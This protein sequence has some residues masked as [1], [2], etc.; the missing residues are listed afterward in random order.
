MNPTLLIA[1]AIAVIIDSTIKIDVVYPRIAKQDSIARINHVP[2]NFVFGSVSPA[3]AK[4]KINRIAVPLEESGAF[5]AYLP[6]DWETQNYIFEARVDS[7]HFANHILPFVDRADIHTASTNEVEQDIEFPLEL[8]L[9]GGVAR[10][11]PQGVYYLFPFQN[12]KVEAISLDNGYYQV[13]LSLVKSV[14]VEE[15]HVQSKLPLRNNSKN[16]IA[17]KGIVK[18][19][20]LGEELVIPLS[21]KPLYRVLSTSN[22]HNLSIDVFGV[23]THIDIV[24]YQ[25]PN[26]LIREVVWEVPSNNVMR[27]ELHLSE[28]LWGYKVKYEDSSLRIIVRKPPKIRRGVKG[29]TIA[30]DPGHG[31]NNDGSIGPLRLAEKEINLKVALELRAILVSKGASV[32]L[33]RESDVDVD[34]LERVKMAEEAEADLMISIHHNAM[35]DGIDPFDNFG[36]GTHYYNPL[37]HGLAE[38]IQAKVHHEINLYDEGVYYNNLAMIRPTFMPAVLLEAAYMMIPE[39]EQMMLGRGYPKA[40]AKAIYKGIK[41]Y[42]DEEHKQSRIRNSSSRLNDYSADIFEN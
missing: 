30:V 1:L 27:L 21:S 11:H 32:M 24:S 41:S 5:L 8:T 6:V 23:T 17:W 18:D 34:L 7:L 37:S 20:K 31:G 16:P 42:L 28:K 35:G 38:I 12:T 22:S 33:S 2:F 14:W 40:L 9:S 13:P 10:S 29:L 39:H 15:R 25:N 3:N 19:I 26:R 4:L 36:T